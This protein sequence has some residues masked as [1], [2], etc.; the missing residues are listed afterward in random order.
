MLDKTKQS[1]LDPL[2][3]RF[4]DTI[5]YWLNYIDELDNKFPWI[6]WLPEQ[7]IRDNKEKNRLS[8]ITKPASLILILI[9]TN[10]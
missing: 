9:T 2:Y 7:I 5:K 3:I 8:R 10:I 1:I 4:T 6:K